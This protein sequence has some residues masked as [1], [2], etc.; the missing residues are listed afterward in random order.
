MSDRIFQICGTT[1]PPLIGRKSA[2]QRLES[3]LTKAT[4][5]HLQV[6]GPRFAGKT[7][8]LHALAEKMR[9]TGSPYRAL[10]LWDLGHQTPD[11]DERFLLTLRDRTADAIDPINKEYAAHLRSAKEKPYTELCE[12]FDALQQEGIK[13]LML[14]DGFDKPLG[15]GK[16]TRNLW[17]QLRELASR[18]SLRLVTASRKQLHEL[19]RSTESASSDFWSIFDPQ[20]VKLECFDHDDVD[21]AISRLPKVT[22]APGARTEM[23][24]WSGGFPPLLLGVLNAIHRD[25]PGGSVDSAALNRIAEAASHDSDALLGSMWSDCPQSSKDLFHGLLTA[26]SVDAAKCS[27]SDLSPLIEKGFA[28]KIGSKVH[29]NCRFLERFIANHVPDVGSMLRLFGTPEAFRA[30]ARQILERRLSHLSNPDTTLARFLA[31]GIDDLPDHP[32]VCLANVRGIVD[33]ALD[34]VWAVELPGRTIPTE[35]FTAWQFEGEKGPEQ[36]WNGQFPNARRGHQIR[37]LHLLT[38]TEKSPPR[39]KVVTRATYALVSAA[40]GFGDFGQHLENVAID[41]GVAFAAMCICLELA[42]SLDRDLKT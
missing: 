39:A 9:A 31:G 16:L 42:A 32:D 37:L 27:Y 36:Y 41:F 7:V 2:L 11:S 24:N 17:D 33:R 20:P 14:W 21:E 5:D 12:V 35:Y 4:P 15:G 3:G 19:I 23:L 8:L 28:K 29:S 34:L 13:M 22:L 40:H 6:V 18:P 38:G 26:G 30:N 1:V 25:S 10:V